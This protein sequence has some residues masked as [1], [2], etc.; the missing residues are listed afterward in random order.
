MSFV[1]TDAGTTMLLTVNVLN[2]NVGVV[3]FER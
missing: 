1:E 2:E 3:T